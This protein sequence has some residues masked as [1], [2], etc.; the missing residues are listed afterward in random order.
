VIVACFLNVGVA[1][2]VWTNLADPV[3]AGP[4]ES[5]V[6]GFAAALAD[7]RFEDAIPYLSDQLRAQTI[8]ETLA[9][10]ITMLEQK[11][12]RLSGVR[13]VPQWS[14]ESR[15]FAS[16]HMNT[17]KSGRLTL[18]FGLVRQAGGDWR[19]DELYDLGWK[20]PALQ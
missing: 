12:G 17:E 18:G 11:T 13:G 1:A 6:E 16:A 2:A 14:K 9:V 8:G 10:R 19:I 20:P 3:P 15:A 5:V 7:H 4:P